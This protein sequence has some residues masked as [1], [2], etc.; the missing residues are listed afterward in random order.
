MIQKNVTVRPQLHLPG[1]LLSLYLA[2]LEA[3]GV[4]ASAICTGN[5]SRNGRGDK[6]QGVSQSPRTLQGL[7]AYHSV[8]DPE[9]SDLLG[10]WIQGQA[11]PINSVTSNME[12]WVGSQQGPRSQLCAQD[13]EGQQ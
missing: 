8:P 9:E 3:S 7:G 2:G 4:R 1:S 11:K 6:D 10:V 5:Y 13:T 12:G